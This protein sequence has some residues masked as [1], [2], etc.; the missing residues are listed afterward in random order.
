MCNIYFYVYV[1]VFV[2]VLVFVFVFVCVV[3]RSNIFE[4]DYYHNFEIK[5]MCNK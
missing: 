1:F 3:L 4:N 5:N 2:F